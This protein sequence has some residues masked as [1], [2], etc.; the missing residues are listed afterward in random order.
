MLVNSGLFCFR[1]LNPLK[2]P[3]GQPRAGSSPAPSIS[4]NQ[5]LTSYSSVKHPSF[6]SLRT[7]PLRSKPEQRTFFSLFSSSQPAAFPEFLVDYDI[8]TWGQ[9]GLWGQIFRIL[10]SSYLRQKSCP[11]KP[12]FCP[13]PMGTNLTDSDKLSF[14]LRNQCVIPGF[15]CIRYLS[16][17]YLEASTQGNVNRLLPSILIFTSIFFLILRCLWER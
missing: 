15:C 3:W 4:Y 11:Q 16:K 2:I 17:Q 14:Q 7:Q 5:I 1:Q 8:L 10:K 6:L 9:W 12:R 13:Q